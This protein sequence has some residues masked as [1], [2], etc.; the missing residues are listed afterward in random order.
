MGIQASAVAEPIDRV[1]RGGEKVARSRA[2]E[3]FA[4]SGFLA[5]GLVYG[6]IG[7]LAVKLAVG[8]GGKTTNQQGALRT[9]AHQP[10]GKLLLIL[11]AVGLA[12]YTVW[13]LV[14]ALLGHGPEGSDDAVERVA[15][16]ASGLVY[17]GFCVIAVEIVL[18]AGA[19]GSGNAKTTTADVF[20]WPGG[21][22]LVGVAGLVF[23]GLGLYQGHRGVSKKFLEDSKTEEMS[24]AVKTW[25]EWV[26]TFGHLARMVVFGLVGVFLVKAAIDF[27]PSKAVGLDGALASLLHHSYGP[28]MLGVVAAGLVTFALYSI[29]DAR[30][31]RI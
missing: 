4:R 16:L 13:R 5:R 10:F 8:V 12:G 14:R 11:V 27:N 30:Y 18:G 2:F 9:V 26:G 22:W 24:R 3:W 15:A 23:V 7:V 31:R 21:R 25:I 6:I 19:R 28:A 1:R 29:S 20:S 17:G